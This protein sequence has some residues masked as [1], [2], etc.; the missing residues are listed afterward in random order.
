MAQW[1]KAFVAKP[2]DLSS[3]FRTDMW[4][5]RETPISVSSKYIQT[6]VRV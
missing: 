6:R 5:E 3:V 2:A 1:V 4:K